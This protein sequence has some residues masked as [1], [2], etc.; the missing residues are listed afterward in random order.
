LELKVHF[1]VG[2]A[3]PVFTFEEKLVLFVLVLPEVGLGD[4]HVLALVLGCESDA[5]DF[6]FNFHLL[7]FLDVSFELHGDAGA[8]SLGEKLNQLFFVVF[9]I[10][11]LE[12]MAGG[13]DLACELVD[14]RS[15][16]FQLRKG[17]AMVVE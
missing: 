10:F 6:R 8:L 16:A 2:D 17:D 14:N 15:D 4:G 7:F 13:D 5:D 3:F 1:F 9:P 11:E 12:G